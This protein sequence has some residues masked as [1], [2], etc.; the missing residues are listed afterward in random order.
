[1]KITQLNDLY[2][3]EFISVKEIQQIVSHLA[4]QIKN[5][6]PEN[7]VPMFVGILNQISSRE[8]HFE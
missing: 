1:M 8:T 2:F 5:D 7:E 3:K 6:L 4:T